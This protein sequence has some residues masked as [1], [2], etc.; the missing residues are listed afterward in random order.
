MGTPNMS[1]KNESPEVAE[2]PEVQSPDGQ[3]TRLKARAIRLARRA[4]LYAGLFLL[5]WV[6]LYGIT[7]A[8]FNH[9]GLF[10][11]AKIHPV[12]AGQF[13]DG[14]LQDFPNPEALAKQVIAALQSA[15]PNAEITLLEAHG[16]A[17]NNNIILQTQVEGMKHV[18]HI[19][20]LSHSAKVVVPSPN[21]EQQEQSRLLGAVRNV[22]LDPNPYEMARA[23]V[24]DIMSAA[25]FHAATPP[26]PQG[27]CKLNFLAD[28]NGEPA[29]VTYVLRDGH[30]DVTRFTG[31]DGMMARQFFLRL[32]TFHGRSPGWSARNLWSLFIDAMAIAM[33]LWGITGLIMWWQLKSIRLAGGI[34]LLISIIVAVIVCL[35]LEHFH[36]MTKM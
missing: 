8:M 16:A 36:A 34:V 12:P 32:H 1:E 28:V 19:D 7:G 35:N 6:F 18:V 3:T 15:A 4:H 31:E 20:P 5:P 14:S 17:F 2:E 10:P 9:Q 26:R 21:E 30:V 13:A 24:P 22:K 11:A 25:G 23:A 33:V 29:R 27:W